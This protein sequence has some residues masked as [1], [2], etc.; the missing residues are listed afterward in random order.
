MYVV[1]VVPLERPEKYASA[2]EQKNALLASTSVKGIVVLAPPHVPVFARRL[3]DDTVSVVAR[4]ISSVIRVAKAEWIL[5]I[6]GFA[7]EYSAARS[8]ERAT[9]LLNSKTRKLVCV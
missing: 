2:I 6:L 5:T 9:M 3:P 7:L 8:S 1:A 4:V